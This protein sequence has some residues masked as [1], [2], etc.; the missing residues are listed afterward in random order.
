MPK[1]RLE[2]LAFAGYWDKRYAEE[3][4]EKGTDGQDVLE[5]F[6][7]FKTFEKLRGWLEKYMPS[8]SEECH[9]LHLGC[10]NSVC[11]DGSRLR[12]RA[13]RAKADH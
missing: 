9:I 8:P 2:E 13:M 1:E 10:G 12:D 4:K 11:Y 6:E 3:A 7:W 5:S